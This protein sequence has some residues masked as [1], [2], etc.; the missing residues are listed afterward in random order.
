MA[1]SR[2]PS[3]PTQAKRGQAVI[4]VA[5]SEAPAAKA[6]K[7]QRDARDPR[8]T[9]AMRQYA[10]FKALHPECLLLFRMGDFYELFDDDAVTA[11]K[12]LGITL[13]QRT[14]GIPMAGVPYHAVESYLRRL[15]N[16]GFRVAVCDQMQDAS[17]A[18]GI[19]DRA[20]TRVLTPGTLVDEQ[21]LDEGTPNRVVCVQFTGAGDHP[22]ACIACAEL[23]TG[24]FTVMAVAGDRVID[25]IV[26][27]G[28]SEIVYAETADG[29]V[30]PRVTAL[31][32]G[33]P[34]CA[35]TARPG[36]SFRQS[37]AAD[38]LRDH[39]GVATLK[40]FGFEDDDDMLAPAGALL[41]YLRD[42]QAA[43]AA[44]S[45]SRDREGAI[46]SDGLEVDS[47]HRHPSI[48]E[49]SLLH[50]RGS[51]ERA[52]MQ[53]RRRLGHLR[54]PRLVN[55]EQ[56]LV[57]DAVSLRSLEIDRT[58]R[59]GAHEG[60]LLWV[61]QRCATSM[62]KRLLRQWL[63]YPLRDL[64]TI[65]ERQQAVGA[66]VRDTITLER[67]VETLA[68]VQDVAR[69]AGRLGLQRATPRD[70]VALGKSLS[71][72]RAMIDLV[73]GLPELAGFHQR[74][75]TIAAVLEPLSGSMLRQCVESP[76]HH[77]REGG[78]FRDGIDAELDSARTLQRD[79]HSW[80]AEYQQQLISQT[81]IASLKVAYNKVFGYF[82]EVTNS[83]RAKVP[84]TF[85]RR[86]TVRNA[87]RYIT[88]ELKTFEDKVTTAEARALEREKAM[89]EALC[90]EAA[91][92]SPAIL[93]F[94][95]IVATL[96]V[97]ACFADTARRNR[98][99]QPEMVEQPVLDIRQG[100]H[101]V[102]DRTLAQQ[103]V[104]ND[105]VLGE[106]SKHPNVET[107]KGEVR[108][109]ES[110]VGQEGQEP[111]ADCRQLTATASLVLI[112]GPN[113][114]GKSTFIRQTALIVLLAHT[115]CWVPAE[116]A[117]IGLVDRIFTRIGASDEIHAGQSTFMVEMTE[118]ANIL[119][120]ATP[121]SLVIL[122]EI[123]RGTST[124]DGLSLAWAIAECIAKIGCRTL[125]ATHYHEI[126]AMADELPG[127]T[128]LHVA[129]REWQDRIIFLYRILPGKTDRSYG[130]HVA[131]IAGLPE[132]A[133]RRANQLLETLAV[134]EKEIAPAEYPSTGAVADAPAQ[135]N[136]KRGASV[137]PGPNDQL[138]LFTQYMS[139]PAVD[140]LKALDLDAM[141][142]IQAFD[143]LRR[144]KERT[145]L[146]DSGS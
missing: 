75:A 20:V 146:D 31:K 3:T 141:T 53:A 101:P 64:T 46:V 71:T 16:K 144:L 122:D 138:S 129:V 145:I 32:A 48:S 106:T 84:A 54:P 43:D 123:G 19:V 35:L 45:T 137:A 62:G 95:E 87:E 39:F 120:H 68:T 74:L 119:H 44:D 60:S 135:R 88:A 85:T 7:D 92:R 61:L 36:W 57:I 13:T 30:P 132:S 124:L 80:L 131:K 52:G 17:E 114:A 100:R 73:S 93:D 127:V 27:L 105:C 14:A 116:R 128:N 103:F 133:I 41:R 99:V 18:K 26:R 55:A 11:H 66:F 104:P 83:H 24:E 23:S 25:E 28:P 10:R 51:P 115:G 58:M 4:E 33:L 47:A 107:S 63:C 90:A 108:G 1:V 38:C 67:L 49:K 40:G 134:H 97:L 72:V 76:P 113:M 91:A 89:F 139:H 29:A 110:E 98:Y 102:L 143:A 5:T 81:A 136:R 70:V 117:T 96:D 130:I 6:A 140:E 121:R 142:P 126:T 78:L 94:A 77:M 8:N 112:T 79:S 37:D 118:T 22:D 15:I 34:A 56:F 9:P 65:G 82:I 111:T 50:G 69:I 125:F 59:T 42:T 109:Q 86:Q 2:G 12:A 21:L